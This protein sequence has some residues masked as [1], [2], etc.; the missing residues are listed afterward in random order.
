[1]ETLLGQ[2]TAHYGAGLA[3]LPFSARMQHLYL[4]G[5]SGTGKSTLMLNLAIQDI[6]AGQGVAV[7]DPHGDLV[8]ELLQHI[9]R[10]RTRDVIYLNLADFDHP[11]AWNPLERQAA[12]PVATLAGHLLS[13]CKHIWRDSW[14]PRME[15]L[16]ANS[17]HALIEA[18]ETLLSLPAL[19]TDARYREAITSRLLDPKVR[20]YFEVEFAALDDRQ[21]TEVIS[22]VQNKIGQLLSHEAVRNV[23]A[24]RRGRLD[25][26][27]ILDTKRILLVNLAK[28]LIGEE[29]A[30]LFGSILVSSIGAVA[31]ARSSL[32]AASRVPFFLYVDEFQNFSTESFASMLSEVRKFKLGL[33]VANQFLG[34][35]SEP[36]RS[37]VIGNVATRVFFAVGSEDAERL[38][39]EIA[40]FPIRHL[41]E[42]APYTGLLKVSGAEAIPIAL[43]PPLDTHRYKRWRTNRAEVIRSES[44][45]RFG[46]NRSK[47]RDFAEASL[48]HNRLQKVN[49]PFRSH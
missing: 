43:F 25:L 23:F 36:V 9:P 21:R 44:R 34:Q 22:P 10:G 19:L 38:R 26:P 5:K 35:L 2:T 15:Y 11:V 3:Q 1:M 30:N 33:V 39:L 31:L 29:P 37:A 48:F 4:L 41:E 27:H 8:E 47:M 12:L 45:R 20:Q 13:A 28:G 6:L 7:I 32:P 14:G 17:L 40:P 16:L 46:R 18:G 24:M 49:L 42:V